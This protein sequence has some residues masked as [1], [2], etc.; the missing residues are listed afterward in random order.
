MLMGEQSFGPAT[1]GTPI[2]CTKPT[3]STSHCASHL[4][5]LFRVEESLTNSHLSPLRTPRH[6]HSYDA[7]SGEQMHTNLRKRNTYT[8]H[9]KD[10][11]RADTQTPVTEGSNVHK[12]SGAHE[13]QP[14][15]PSVKVA[16]ASRPHREPRSLQAY[17]VRSSSH[18]HAGS[19]RVQYAHQPAAVRRVRYC[20][21]GFVSLNPNDRR[22]AEGTRGV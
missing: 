5:P 8:Q 18:P 10:D 21:S 9:N 11:Q 6:D 3:P 19:T 1:F 16:Q 22:R 13:T 14:H 17:L 7:V 2:H 15:I 20:P 12:P 4:P